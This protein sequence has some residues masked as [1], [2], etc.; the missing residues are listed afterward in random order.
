MNVSIDPASFRDPSGFVFSSGGTLYRQVQL[1]YRGEYDRLMQSGLYSALV[2]QELLIP[3]EEEQGASAA[4]PNGY[5]ILRP[6]RLPFVSYPYEWCFSQLRDAA[7]ATL[8][9]QSE[10]LK[11]GMSLKDATA[12][13]IQFRA[14]KPVLI[15]TLSFEVYEEG[16]TW[17]A[18][19][20]FCE[21]FLAPL[22]LLSKTDVRLQHLLRTYLDGIPLD[23]ARRLLPGSTRFDAGLL[24]HIHIHGAAQKRF[25]GMSVTRTEQS[26]SMSRNAMLGLMDSLNSAIR[27]LQWKP[28]GTEWADYYKST[29]Y[30]DKAMESKRRIVSEM[31]DKTSPRPGSLWDLGANAGEFSRV[32]AGKCENVI[33]WDVDPAAVEINY[34]ECSKAGVTNVLPLVQDLTNPSPEIGWELAERKSF[35][36]RGP[37]DALLALALVHHLA[38]GNNVPLG[39]IAQ[40]FRRLGVWLIVEFVPK[41][42]SQTQRLLAAKRDVFSDYNQARFESEFSSC[43]E[44][45]HKAAV[46]E[47]ERTLYL[48]RGQG[49][50]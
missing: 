11:R 16:Q 50:E 26:R 34:L 23:L 25:E 37:A 29:N 36:S 1:S 14:G 24:T 19:R 22:A 32:A 38:I 12:Y 2:E 42:D 20:Q 44:I 33:A 28:A 9:I 46:D 48:M 6:E 49:H 4:A 41:S 5:R 8:T 15:D 43:F 17:P 7:L 45:A 13:N 40:F 10:A 31:L 18:Y 21:H 39:R 35:V 30:S 3:H 27:K 47:S